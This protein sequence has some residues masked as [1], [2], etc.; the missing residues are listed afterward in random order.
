MKNLNKIARA[1]PLCK[2]LFSEQKAF[3]F[4]LEY[5]DETI[6][7]RNIRSISDVSRAEKKQSFLHKIS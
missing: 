5:I 6:N 7:I 4:V 2:E 3:H 1:N